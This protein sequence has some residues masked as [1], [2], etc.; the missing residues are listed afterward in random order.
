MTLAVI[1]V[2]L[3]IAWLCSAP[4]KPAAHGWTVGRIENPSAGRDALIAEYAANVD[5]LKALVADAQEM[6]RRTNEFLDR[7][8]SQRNRP[9]TRPEARAYLHEVV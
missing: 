6:T 9:L 7:Y 5:R 1:I 4:I 3:G 2:L 8:D